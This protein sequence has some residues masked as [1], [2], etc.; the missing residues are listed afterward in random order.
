MHAKRLWGGESS[1][2]FSNNLGISP[3]PLPRIPPPGQKRKWKVIIH[4]GRTV[5]D[6][7]LKSPRLT[8]SSECVIS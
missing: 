7:I 3:L 8:K 6:K 5:S 2:V 1:G 4:S